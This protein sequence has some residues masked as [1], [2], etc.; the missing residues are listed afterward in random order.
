MRKSTKILFLTCMFVISAM[1][2]IACSKEK[3]TGNNGTAVQ[4]S[5][6]P[7]KAAGST[8]AAQ[9]VTPIPTAA[10]AAVNNTDPTANWSE[11]MKEM[12][13]IK[14]IDLVKEIKIGWN[15]GNTMDATGA[16]TVMAETSW[17]NPKTT[18]K[19]IDKVKAAGFNTIRIPTTWEPHLGSAPDYTIDPAWLDRVQ[20]IVDYGISNDMFVIV[21]AHH[22]EWYSPTY[23]NAD[24][25]K[26]MMAKVWKQIAD[27]FENYDEHLIFEGLNEA[28]QKGTS[29][30]WNGGNAEGWDVIN[31][32]N[33]VFVDTIRSAGGNNPLRHLMI[34]P[35]A[36]SSSTRAWD[37]FIV[38]ED[39]KI[40][41]S[42]HAYTPYNF[43]LNKQGTAEW[44]ATNPND[45]GEIDNLMN[46]IYNK[47]ISNGIP[48][49]LGEFGAVNKNDNVSARVAWAEYYVSK[50]AEKGI[51]CIWW[52]NG[53]FYGSGELFGL[54]DRNFYTWKC[55]ELV[56]A[57]IK[58]AK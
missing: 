22:E 45:T 57:L 8:E 56:D 14:S 47:F 20:E 25:A 6:A 9:K 19:L 15:L 27:R 37:S 21:N 23:A 16:T 42:I 33:Q 48:V 58:N 13:D 17:G 44:S 53:S 3:S 41:I 7:T 18:K 55:P 46:N 30:E 52:D 11:E 24:K 10:P 2:L 54:I 49:I 38:P 26:D 5:T 40:I 51:P 28:R 34:A 32:L 29:D 50:A 1:L 43:A 36:A 35:Y 31:Q 39:N 4:T 12:R